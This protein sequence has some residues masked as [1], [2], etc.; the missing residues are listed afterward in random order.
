MFV[1]VC[2]VCC[3]VATSKALFD[4]NNWKKAKACL[5]C[6]K[7]GCLSDIPGFA[8]Y[9]EASA[10]DADGL[11]IYTC[12]RG[13]NDCENVHQKLMIMLGC[14]VCGPQLAD[15]LMADWRHHHNIRMGQLHEGHPDT[16]T[17]DLEM[18]ER[19]KVLHA[20]NYP[21]RPPLYP[22]LPST[23]DIVPNKTLTFGVVALD[24]AVKDEMGTEWPNLR[25]DAV[26]K[27]FSDNE[28]FLSERYRVPIPPIPFG[29]ER[30]EENKLFNTLLGQHPAI[31]DVAREWRKRVD[32][33]KFFPK[34]HQHFESKRDAFKKTQKAAITQVHYSSQ[35]DEVHAYLQA[36][37][38]EWMTAHY[39][40]TP[41]NPPVTADPPTSATQPE[42]TNSQLVPL[43]A[44]TTKTKN[45]KKRKQK[46]VAPAESQQQPKKRTVRFVLDSARGD[47]LEFELD[48][49]AET[50]GD[51]L[52]EFGGN[53][54]GGSKKTRAA[55]KCKQ[56]GETSCPQANQGGRPRTKVG[57][58]V[59]RKV[60]PRA[61]SS[62]I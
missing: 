60:C 45:N 44:S 52:F 58:V 46:A 25:L 26:R 62:S 18:V 55:R 27:K 28:K 6:I 4:K 23:Q 10:P 47:D 2:C 11:P 12:C 16:G 41:T 56:C 14:T 29:A 35:V 17:S 9:T 43:V 30:K 22:R 61:P 13:T 53:G 21:N 50:G 49:Q 1:R 5:R 34:I 19:I 8:Y 38:D 59:A 33:V 3:V 36:M 37:S 24:D 7:K 51:D 40:A 39:A 31:V 48:P 54:S 15:Y 32:G 42:V 57:G 20:A